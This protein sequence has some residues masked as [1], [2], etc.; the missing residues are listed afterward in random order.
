MRQQLQER[1]DV[2][3]I[4]I[5]NDLLGIRRHLTGGAADILGESFIGKRVGTKPR[6]GRR[7]A[8]GFAAVALITAI[9]HIDALPP[10]GI[11]G[12]YA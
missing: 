11:S 12:R 4:L 5:R 7:R 1:T 9:L 8:L 10:G 6:S 2:G 3:Q